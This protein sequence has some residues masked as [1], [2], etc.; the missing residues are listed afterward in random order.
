MKLLR[1]LSTVRGVMAWVAIVAML[2]WGCSV[3]RSWAYYRSN[4]LF[5]SEC[6]SSC[7]QELAG[8]C[9]PM[10][11]CGMLGHSSHNEY[12]GQHHEAA[13][14]SSLLEELDHY[15]ARKTKYAHA[16][17]LPWISLQPDPTTVR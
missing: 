12:D 11:V 10:V 3:V 9:P 8:P 5:F 13:W 6:E 15:R 2:I 4:Y 16:M 14:R 1:N 7:L 17:W